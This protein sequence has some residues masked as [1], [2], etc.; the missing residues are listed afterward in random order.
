MK[1]GPKNCGLRAEKANS[2]SEPKNENQEDSGSDPNG[3]PPLA[4]G[5]RPP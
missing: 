3:T 5:S 2:G 4:F 1:L